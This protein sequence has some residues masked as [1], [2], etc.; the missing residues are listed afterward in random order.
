MQELNLNKSFRDYTS[1]RR[2]DNVSSGISTLTTNRK[3]F[4]AILKDGHTKV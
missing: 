1:C 2:L 3:I 4:Q